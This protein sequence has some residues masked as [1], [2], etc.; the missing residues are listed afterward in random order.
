VMRAVLEPAAPSP[1]ST[2]GPI[3]QEALDD[4]S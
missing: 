4:R 1:T 2:V 3:G